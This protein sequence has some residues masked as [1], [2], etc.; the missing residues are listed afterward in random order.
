MRPVL[1]TFALIS[2]AT[3]VDMTHFEQ[4]IRPLL[5]ANCIECHGADKQKGGLRLD[6]R[7]GWQNGGD[8]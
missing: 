7:A 8:S 1:L 4:R 3:A 6:S 5:L 2:T